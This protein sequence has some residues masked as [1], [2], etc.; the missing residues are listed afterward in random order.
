MD[1]SLVVLETGRLWLRR[2]TLSDLE[3]LAPIYADREVMRYIGDGATRTRATVYQKLLERIEAE[4]ERG[5]GMWAVVDRASGR[6]IGE[7]GLSDWDILGR[8]EVELGYILARAFWGEGLA[9]EATRAVRDHAFAALGLEKLIAVIKRSNAAS[10]RVARKIGMSVDQ[11]A[12][13]LAAGVETYAISRSAWRQ[14]VQ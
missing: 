5:Y 10:V 4:Q 9:T 13:V 14:L 8:R 6:L 11:E 7:C 1:R 3:A 2:Q 12:E